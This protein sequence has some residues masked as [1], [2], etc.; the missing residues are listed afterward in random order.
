MEATWGREWDSR[1]GRCVSNKPS[2][3]AE[4]RSRHERLHQDPQEKPDAD[5]PDKSPQ[6]TVWHAWL[7]MSPLCLAGKNRS[8]HNLYNRIVYSTNNNIPEQTRR[9]LEGR[10]F[11][12]GFKRGLYTL[13]CQFARLL[14]KPNFEHTWKIWL[15][16]LYFHLRFWVVGWDLNARMYGVM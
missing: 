10:I 9:L 2:P 13:T 1:G 14:H 16:I 15:C 8:L 3:H 5:K 7:G 11:R 12:L 6:G 4:Q